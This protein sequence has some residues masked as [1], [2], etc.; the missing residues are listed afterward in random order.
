MIVEALAFAIRRACGRFT[1]C[2]TKMQEMRDRMKF[3]QV[4][5]KITLDKRRILSDNP[6]RMISERTFVAADTPIR[7][8]KAHLRE[9]VKSDFVFSTLLDCYP[10]EFDPR[11]ALRF[12][13]CTPHQSL[14]D[15]FDGLTWSQCVADRFLLLPVR[16]ALPPRFFSHCERSAPRPSRGS[17]GESPL[18]EERVPLGG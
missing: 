14:R 12:S 18:L 13:A 4:I 3:I 16:P 6:F 1:A 7:G 11:K 8:S 5:R 2:R 10:D 9:G 17:L 15:S